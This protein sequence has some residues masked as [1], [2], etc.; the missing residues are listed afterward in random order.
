ML[1]ADLCNKEDLPL[2]QIFFLLIF[3]CVE[4]ISLVH[5]LLLYFFP[6]WTSLSL[7]ARQNILL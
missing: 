5:I 3:K 4:D 1:P 6:T 7:F 2:L